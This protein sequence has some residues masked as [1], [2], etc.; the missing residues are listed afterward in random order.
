SSSAP[1]H[2]QQQKD[3]RPLH[4]VPG[5]DQRSLQEAVAARNKIMHFRE[6]AAADERTVA[7]LPNLIRVSAQLLVDLANGSE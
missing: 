6:L 1:N 5:L 3:H 4:H 7:A 2:Y